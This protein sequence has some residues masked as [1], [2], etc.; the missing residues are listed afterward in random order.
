METRDIDREW[1]VA[2]A[3]PIRLVSAGVCQLLALILIITASYNFVEGTREIFVVLFML[4]ATVLAGISLYR[5]L[6]LSRSKIGF[7]R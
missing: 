6:R 2:H 4:A 1:I 7:S 5:F 3:Q